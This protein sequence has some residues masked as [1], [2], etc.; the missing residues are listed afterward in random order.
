MEPQDF[1]DLKKLN[2]KPPKKAQIFVGVAV[3]LGLVLFFTTWFQV[4][5]NSEGVILRLGKF[6]RMVGPGLHLK[7]PFGV[8]SV[9][10]V[11]S[12]RQ[13]KEEYGFRTLRSGT[14]TQFSQQQFLKESL[15][16]T[17]DLNVAEVE[18]SVQ[19]RIADPFKYLFR[20]RNVRDSFRDITEAVMREV[21]GDRTVNEVLTVGRTELTQVV[22]DELQKLCIQY[23]TGIKV[24]QVILQDVAPPDAVKPSFNE[25]NQAQQEREKL[26]NEARGQYN[27]EVPRAR[28]RADQEIS[29]AEGYA[30]DRVNRARG[31]ASRFEQLYAE[32][33][34]APE[35][36]RQRIYIET[37][38]QVLPKVGRKFIIDENTKG[39]IPFLQLGKGGV[40][41]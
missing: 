17:G 30:I 28:G 6:N 9:T 20:V 5:A 25:V 40:G 29:Q 12:Q 23:E 1:I 36:T 4:E 11:P 33:R 14:R 26:I 38:S 41:Q 24:E 10:L 18:W 21:V 22:E 19:Y 2:F 39:L 15:M 8:E 27:L 34:K 31:E 3:L 13:L 16:L 7:I 32:Y 35:V 37:M